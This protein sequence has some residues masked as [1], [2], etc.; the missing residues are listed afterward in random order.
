MSSHDV[1]TYKVASQN[2]KW[3]L[4]LPTPTQQHI[5]IWINGKL[6]DEWHVPLN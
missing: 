3:E 5:F 2:I 6:L 4:F 1:A